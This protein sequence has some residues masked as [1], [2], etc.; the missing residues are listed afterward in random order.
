ME[1][2][3]GKIN[4]DF[5]FNPEIELK[6]EEVAALASIVAHPGFEVM[7]RVFRTCVDWFIKEMIN[8]N[9]SNE[10]DIIAKH[11]QA[12]TAAQLYTLFLGVIN[13]EILQYVHSQPN[14]KPVDSGEGLDLQNTIAD[15]EMLI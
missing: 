3:I 5:S 14:N 1:G 11:N 8:A 15:G 7:K 4:K 2:E 10:K 13:E 6:K 9:V 12:K